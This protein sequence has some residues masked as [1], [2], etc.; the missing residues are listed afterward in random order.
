MPADKQ[1]ILAALAEHLIFLS[2]AKS[3][4]YTLNTSHDHGFH[5]A[6]RFGMT[7]EHYVALLVAADLAK[8]VNG[9]LTIKLFQWETFLQ[10]HH[11]SDLLTEK[12][13]EV[14]DK[15]M[16]LFGTVRR[17]NAIGIGIKSMHSPLRFEEQDLDSF[18][19]STNS[20]RCDM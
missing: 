16:S 12:A 7:H 2:G 17:F 5:L 19:P 15:R 1:S 13:I 3:Y 6:N 8:Y 9:V 11:F 14:V 20:S 10:G 4:W 18:P